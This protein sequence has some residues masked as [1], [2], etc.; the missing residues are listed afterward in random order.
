[1]LFRKKDNSS[2]VKAKTSLFAKRAT[3]EVADLPD[4]KAGV[5]ESAPEAIVPAKNV[6]R[7]QESKNLRQ[8]VAGGRVNPNVL[9]SPRITEKA[10]SLS[11]H[12]MYVFDVASFANKK[13]VAAAVKDVY[14]V[15]PVSVRIVN[16]PKK[17]KVS[18][19]GLKSKLGGGKKAY[20]QL[21]QGD[22]IE[23]V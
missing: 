20:V 9:V 2:G 23:L 8:T 11:A 12:N 18:R 16:L 7:A 19:R 5:K 22:T 14:N 4:S 17:M 3:K 6:A 15:T 10:T 1:M 21:K 13:L